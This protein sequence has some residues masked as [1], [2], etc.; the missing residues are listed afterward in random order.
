MNSICWSFV[1]LAPRTALLALFG[2][3]IAAHLVGEVTANEAAGQSTARLLNRGPPPEPA[4]YRHH[5]YRAFVPKT[6]K[7][8]TVIS[9][10]Q[11][12]QIWKS[13]KAIFIDVLPRAPKPQNL[14]KATVWR[15]RKRNNIPDSI[16]LANVGFGVLNSK[17]QSY[18]RK[19]LANLTKGDKTAPIL[20]YCLADC[21]M[22]WNAAK[23]ALTFGYKTVYWYPEGTN[24]WVK[25]GG[26]LQHSEP[27]PMGRR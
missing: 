2:L 1:S 9:N 27:M 20:F 23:R 15:P 12:M 21:W 7:G 25:N 4:D 11:A 18:F 3:C 24:G 13:R 16:W 8:A 22:S 14:R 6:L 17:L 19:T 26:Q 10:E 5:D